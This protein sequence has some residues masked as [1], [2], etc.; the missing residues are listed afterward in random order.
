MTQHQVKVIKPAPMPAIGLAGVNILC[1]DNDPDVLQG[2]IELLSAWQCNIYSASSYSEA[3]HVFAQ[4]QFDIDIMLVDYQLGNNEDGI[5]LMSELTTQVNYPL[6]GILITATTDDAVAVQAKAKGFG[7]MRK[8][9]K[10]AA[11]RSMISAML[12]KSLQG[13]YSQK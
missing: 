4:H 10:P 1:V 13:N 5:S 2:M 12:A 6:P 3:Q 9:V 11:L 7:Y 8:L